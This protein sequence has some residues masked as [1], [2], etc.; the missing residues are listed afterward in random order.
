MAKTVAERA[1]EYRQRHGRGRVDLYLS[2]NA[3]RALLRL[4]RTWGCGRQDVIERLVLER[5][6]WVP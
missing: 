4:S 5:S 1:R 3:Y 6:E 2:P